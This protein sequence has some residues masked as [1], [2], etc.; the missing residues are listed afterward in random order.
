MESGT[1]AEV[2]QNNLEQSELLKTEAPTIKA[3]KE[4]D[5]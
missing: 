4:D 5:S 3:N 1:K 2:I